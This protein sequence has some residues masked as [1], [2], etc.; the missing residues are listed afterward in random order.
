[1]QDKHTVYIVLEDGNPAPLSADGARVETTCLVNVNDE[2][3]WM[4][5]S[6][7]VE[8]EFREGTPFADGVKQGDGTYRSVA[9]N[10]GIFPYVCTVTTPDG[11]KHGW[12][13]SSVGGGTVEVGTGSRSGK[14]N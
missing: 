7:V 6:G 8:V 14:S 4:S 10:A 3:R 1:M 5:E 13:E 2:I 9:A 11:K 12:P